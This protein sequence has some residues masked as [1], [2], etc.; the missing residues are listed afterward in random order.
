MPLDT[1]KHETARKIAQQAKSFC[2]QFTEGAISLSEFL[3]AAIA[4]EA[5]NRALIDELHDTPGS[6]WDLL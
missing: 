4:L 1:E 6:E 5:A 3:F 2:W